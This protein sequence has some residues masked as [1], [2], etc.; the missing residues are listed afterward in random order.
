MQTFQ[1][2]PS[3]PAR[4]IKTLDVDM[5]PIGALRRYARVHNV[6]VPAEEFEE[7]ISGGVYSREPKK[8]ASS[9]L[10]ANAAR[11]H[12]DQRPTRTDLES[13]VSR[14]FSGI[15]AMKEQDVVT[16]FLY[17]IKNKDKVLKLAP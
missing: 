6:R 7:D 17:A 15:G 5:L 9:R 2:A 12:V 8:Y 1:P 3:Q 10:A 4:Q 16:G 14:H 11:A 13:A